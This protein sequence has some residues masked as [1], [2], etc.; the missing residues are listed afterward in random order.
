[1]T[2]DTT[3]G[4]TPAETAER[5]VRL[6]AAYHREPPLSSE[7]WAKLWADEFANG[8]DYER[9]MD[10]GRAARR[11]GASAGTAEPF[12]MFQLTPEEQAARTAKLAA[13]QAGRPAMTWESL[14]GL[15]DDLFEGEDDRAAYFAAV[16]AARRDPVTSGRP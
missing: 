7:D 4:P 5:R 6:A 8:A 12:R 9:F 16:E 1:M 11:T 2:A 15:F 13:A 3:A 14:A 10:A